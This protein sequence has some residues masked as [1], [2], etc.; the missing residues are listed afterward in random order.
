MKKIIFKLVLSIAGF[1]A[2]NG[3]IAGELVKSLKIEIL[4][5]SGRP[6]PT[7]LVT[8]PVQMK[9]I[10]NLAKKLPQNKSIKQDVIGQPEAKLGYQ[11]FIVTNNSDVSSEI[12][13]ILVRGVDVHTELIASSIVGGKTEVVKFAA[14][15]SSSSLE[16]KLLSQAKSKGIVDEKIIK[17][18]E[19]SK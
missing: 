5:F 9:E 16:N 7:F 19:G 2:A 10:L 15:D 13:S 11:G 17:V 1:C 4:L 8:D 14:L 18:I 3:A 12:K 6:N